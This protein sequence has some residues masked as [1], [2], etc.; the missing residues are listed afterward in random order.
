MWERIRIFLSRDERRPGQ[1]RWK[2]PAR[3]FSPPPS[4]RPG[5]LQDPEPQ[6]RVGQ[7]SGIGYELVLVLDV[8]VLRMV[9]QPVDAS[10]LAFFEEEEAK[11]LELGYRELARSASH[12]SPALVER[13]REARAPPEGSWEEEEEEEEE[14]SKNFFLSRSSHS[15]FRTLFYELFRSSRL[16]RLLWRCHEFGGVWV[17]DSSWFSLASTAQRQ[18]RIGLCLQLV[19]WGGGGCIYSDV[20]AGW[21][22]WLRCTS[23]CVSFD[24]AMCCVPFAWR[25]AHVL[26]HHG[27]YEPEGQLIRAQ[28]CG[29]ST[30]AVL[31]Q[32]DM[33][34]V[35]A[36]GADGQTAQKTVQIPH[37]QFL[38]T[39]YIPV[40]ALYVV[41]V[42]VV[43]MQQVLQVFS[44][45]FPSV[46][47]SPK[48]L[49]I[50]AGMNQKNFTWRVYAATV[51]S[52]QLQLIFKVVDI[53]F[54][55]QRPI[56]WSILFRLPWRFPSCP[57]TRWST[58][59][60]GR[61]HLVVRPRQIHM[62]PFAG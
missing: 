33:P 47:F 2:R 52:P 38:V 61:R 40:V 11:V 8:P 51:D 35:I 22:C 31:G 42:P 45:A 29:D 14:D 10:A 30:G 58:S 43:Q 17:F 57:W 26:R 39:V 62:V 19:F 32:G 12:D 15:K 4:M 48:M 55:L 28:T 44:V 54:V 13:L 60:R 9:E 21:F 27:G 16:E 18:S 1:E 25:Q 23:C 56:L 5:V 20:N 49:R 46:I 59:L 37:V 50:M 7:H 34:V 6:W 53:P 24:C 41:D 36:S 3:S